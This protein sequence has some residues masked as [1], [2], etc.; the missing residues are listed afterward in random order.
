MAPFAG[1]L[2]ALV[3]LVVFVFVGRA[4]VKLLRNPKEDH[5]ELVS[6]RERRATTLVGLPLLLVGLA[7]LAG[8]PLALPYN[9]WVFL[10]P[11]GVLTLYPNFGPRSGV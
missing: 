11:G 4:I 6:K 9:A 7:T 3:P 8:G 5:D 1:L 2:N 10:L